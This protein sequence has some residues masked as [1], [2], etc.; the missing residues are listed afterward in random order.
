VPPATPIDAQ[1]Q[2]IP[3]AIVY[4]DDDVIVINK[5]PGMVVHPAPGHPD[6]T[7]V[8]ALLHH[9]ENLSGIGGRIR[10]G[11]VHRIDRDTSGLLVATKNDRAHRCLAEQFAAHSIERVYE[12]VVVRVHGPGLPD[13][14]TIDTPHRRHP[15]HRRRFTGLAGGER[16]AITHVEV[17]LRG[18][19][20]AMRVRCRLSTGR[21]H[22][23]R[24]HLSEKGCPLL[25]DPLYGGRAVVAN[26]WIPR[27]ALH[28]ATLG[29]I[30][31]DGR[32]LRFESALPDDLA[33]AV[34]RL[35]R[36]ETWRA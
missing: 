33:N 23:I 18:V 24:V 8:N 34:L 5:A 9:C 22:Q 21:T 7:L 25:G 35:E 12:A 19:D 4:E 17:V 13:R 10:P 36:G 28:A 27:V 14:I 1:P 32:S 20:G 30:A 31:P 11:I 15:D 6:G 26:R 2:A 29:F 3:L 16:R